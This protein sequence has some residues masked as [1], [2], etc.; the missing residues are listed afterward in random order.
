MKKGFIPGFIT[1][2]IACIILVVAVAC[3]A[4]NRKGKNVTDNQSNTSVDNKNSTIA[5]NTTVTPVVTGTPTATPKL[6]PP[7]DDLDD[8]DF[9]TK[10]AA[11]AR[12]LKMYYYQDVDFNDV[13]DGMYHGMVSGIGDPYTQYFSE[14]EMNAFTESTSGVYAGIGAAV[15][16]GENGYPE[17]NKV[18][19]DGPADK[20]GML[21]GDYIIEIEGEDIHNLSLDIAVT[22]M[23]GEEGTEVHVTVY[24]KGEPDYLHMTVIRGKIEVPTVEWK[25][26]PDTELG[27]II[28]SEFDEVTDKQFSKA[29]EEL[30]AQGMKGLVID[31][32][33][34]P[35]GLLTTVVNMLDRVMPEDKLLVYMDDKAGN[36]DTYKSTNPDSIDMPIAILMNGYSASASEVFAGCLQ[37]YGKAILVGTQSFGKGIVQTLIPLA[38]G[39]GI[40]VTIASYFTPNGRCIHLTGLTP[41]IEV[42]L[43]P[44]L[45]KKSTIKMEEDNQLAKAVEAL[46][47]RIGK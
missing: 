5:D 9:E 36:R 14:D 41:D 3:G 42:E 28:V 37:D 17:L 16:V 15:S 32:R 44:E 21:P 31:L 24:R 8:T 29:V 25:M 6:T 2:L 12:L 23:R 40:K 45:K 1:G 35:G 46:K 19:A 13:V 11:I 27:Y 10:V 47:E 22:K 20:A 26:I 33:S 7:A 30:T 18:F 34:N 43:D 39:S 4:E 38:D